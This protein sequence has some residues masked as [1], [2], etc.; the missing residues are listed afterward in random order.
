MLGDG[1]TVTC[2]QIDTV[3]LKGLILQALYVPKFKISLTPVSDSTRQ[4]YGHPLAQET[5]NALFLKASEAYSLEPSM[6]EST[7]WTY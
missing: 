4:D 3:L 1:K 6:E 2:T 5:G 7:P